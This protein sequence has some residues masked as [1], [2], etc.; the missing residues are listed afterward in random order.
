[1]QSAID[2]MVWLVRLA[3]VCLLGE[4]GNGLLPRGAELLLGGHV[5]SLGQGNEEAMLSALRAYPQVSSPALCFS[6]SDLLSLLQGLQVGG[7]I[8]PENARRYIDAGKASLSRLLLSQC[9]SLQLLSS[10]Y[11]FFHRCFPCYRYFVPLPR[12]S[13]R[14]AASRGIDVATVFFLLPSFGCTAVA[15]AIVTGDGE[16]RWKEAPRNRLEVCA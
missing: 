13:T 3:S 4:R 12:R 15:N 16:K 10:W 7:G 1:M 5:I 11:V 6:L 2:R 8:T 9:G 14:Q